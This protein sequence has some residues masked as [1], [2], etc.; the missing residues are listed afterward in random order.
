MMGLALTVIILAIAVYQY[1]D[2]LKEEKQANQINE[3]EGVISDARQVK[4][5]ADSACNDDYS[6]RVRDEFTKQ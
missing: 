6:R 1:N 2:G 3:D 5:I 4:Q